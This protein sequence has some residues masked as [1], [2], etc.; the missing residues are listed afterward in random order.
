MTGPPVT[1]G[2]LLDDARRAAHQGMT[3][4]A[5][6]RLADAH[7]AHDALLARARLLAPAARHAPPHIGAPRLDALRAGT[8]H[9][10]SP[11]AR[12]PAVVAAL[13][14]IDALAPGSVILGW[15]RLVALIWPNSSAAGVS[16]SV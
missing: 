2:Q 9:R 1:Y 5:R 14:W 15:P 11:D 12:A 4:L 7:D 6:H 13:A 10:R 16:L 3:T 8:P